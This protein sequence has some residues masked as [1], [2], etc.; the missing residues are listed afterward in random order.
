MVNTMPKQIVDYVMI[1]MINN[2]LYVYTNLATT[3][4]TEVYY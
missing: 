2:Y 4:C 3:K 1:S